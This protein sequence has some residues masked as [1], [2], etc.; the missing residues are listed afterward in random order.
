MGW[1]ER[2][3]ESLLGWAWGFW[4]SF[5]CAGQGGWNKL[6]GPGFRTIEPAGKPAGPR[7][8]REERWDR[9]PGFLSANTRGDQDCR[10]AVEK[11]GLSF[12]K[13]PRRSALQVGGSGLICWFY[14]AALVCK[15]R[16]VGLKKIVWG[17]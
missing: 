8:P 6:E 12:G 7:G 13:G 4:E 10:R 11:L 1:G 16:S 15:T 5:P 3:R 17:M 9:G 14:R 2:R